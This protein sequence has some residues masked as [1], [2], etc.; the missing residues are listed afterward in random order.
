MWSIILILVGIIICGD[1]IYANIIK[2]RLKKWEEN[3][4]RDV[5]G[6]RQGCEEFTEGDGDI[7]LL[8]VHGFGDSP[9]VYT[10]FA[11]ALAKMGFI[12]K[13][14]RLPGFAE[15]MQKYSKTS[16]NLWL[17]KL[18]Q[19]VDL[20]KQKYSKVW[21]I[22]HSLGGAIT[23]RYLLENSQKVDG[24]ILLA[25]LIKVSN[26]SVPFF[27]ARVF[28]EI[29]NHC[30]FITKIFENYIPLDI[31]NIEERKKYNISIDH[32]IPRNIYNGLFKLIDSFKGRWSEIK[33]PVLVILSGNDKVIDTKTAEHFYQEISSTDKQ[34]IILKNS[35]HVIPLDYEWEE[36][37]SAISTFIYKK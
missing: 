27:S 35:G 5:D 34:L 1:F 12:C 30:L 10:K 17:E 25:P 15:P 22:A 32:F 4:K 28:F 8:M 36:V 19:E 20:L 33:L 21:I 9:T 11:P 13:V 23:I 3:V 18:G 6:V 2:Y 31:H 26:Q 29:I 16:L 24:V 14:M 37:V 7:A